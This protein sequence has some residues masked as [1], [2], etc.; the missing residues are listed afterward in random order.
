MVLIQ[1]LSYLSVPEK[2]G[3]SRCNLVGARMQIPNDVRTW[4]LDAQH[5][6]SN[7]CRK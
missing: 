7:V 4:K 3:P 6:R 2:G 5:S 1:L